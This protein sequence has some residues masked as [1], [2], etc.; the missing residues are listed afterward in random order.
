M[1]AA[2]LLVVAAS[3]CGRISSHFSGHTVTRKGT[4]SATPPAGGV[5]TAFALRAGGFLPGEALTF[6]IDPPKGRPFIGPAH[7]AA[8]DGSATGTYTPQGGDP[9]GTYTL[10]A[11]GDRGTRAS[12]SLVV[13]G[14]ATPTTRHP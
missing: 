13:E 7:T 6:E 4:V 12:A 1:A 11:T 10:K 9:P 8:P 2:V 14:S 3:G 5:G